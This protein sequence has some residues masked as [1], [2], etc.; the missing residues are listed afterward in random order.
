MKINKP[1]MKSLFFIFVLFAALLINKSFSQINQL[2]QS[3]SDVQLSIAATNNIFLVG[4][5]STI[6]CQIKNSSTNSISL[7]YPLMLPDDTH[8]FLTDEQG[9]TVELTPSQIYGSSLI[10]PTVDQGKIYTWDKT[11]EI[12]TNINSGKYRLQAARVIH[13]KNG[14]NNKIVSNFLEIE[15]K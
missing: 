6:Q 7:D 2:D 15:I 9:K 13:S 5:N 14:M 3:V 8:L 10:G 1:K 4:T 11:F 12:G